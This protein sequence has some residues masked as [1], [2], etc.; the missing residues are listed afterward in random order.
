MKDIEVEYYAILREERG[1]K[2]EST[3]TT[4][5]TPRDLYI[6]LQKKH[7]FSLSIDN[8]K[9]AINDDFVDWDHHL[10]TN[11]K[12]VFIPPVTGG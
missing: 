5:Q 2:R 3:T 11:D 1:C 6:E 9:P 8:V 7:G 10:Q 4:A 12:I